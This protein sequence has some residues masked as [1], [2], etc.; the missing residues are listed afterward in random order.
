MQQHSGVRNRMTDERGGIQQVEVGAGHES[1]M[2]ERVGFPR[3]EHV[4][5][6][7]DDLSQAGAIFGLQSVQPGALRLELPGQ[8]GE[9][10]VGVDDAPCG[11]DPQGERQ[12]GALRDDVAQRL[13]FGRHPVLAQTGDQQFTGL[14]VGQRP[15]P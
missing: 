5:G 4:V 10:E 2:S 15:Q 3:R 1:E 11:D 9:G 14:R 12:S 13:A 8:C 6:G 7:A